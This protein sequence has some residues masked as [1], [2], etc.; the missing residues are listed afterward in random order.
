MP[1]KKLEPWPCVLTD[2][3]RAS[4]DPNGIARRQRGRVV[5]ESRDGKCWWIEWDG[6]KAPDCRHKS[7]VQRPNQSSEGSNG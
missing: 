2:A 7:F 6:L 5:G 4:L 3:G 1:R